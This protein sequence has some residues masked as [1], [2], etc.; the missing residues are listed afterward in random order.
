MKNGKLILSLAAGL[1]V[2]LS[3]SAQSR[4]QPRPELLRLEDVDHVRETRQGL[5]L[6]AVHEGRRVSVLIDEKSPNGAESGFLTDCRNLALGAKREYRS[7]FVLAVT[8]SSRSNRDRIII[9]A[10]NLTSCAVKFDNA[11]VTPIDYSSRN[12]LTVSNIDLIRISKSRAMAVSGD[13]T[14]GGRFW[15]KYQ[16]VVQLKAR[17]QVGC[18]LNYAMTAALRNDSYVLNL[19]P[20]AIRG[21]NFNETSVSVPTNDIVGCGMD[22]RF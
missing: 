19:V 3:A 5:E 4:Y 18:S 8:F 1:M 15:N 9:D 11:Y 13:F 12:Q 22:F 16:V 6:E 20:G 2:S 7:E 14:I 10:G 21:L 17:S